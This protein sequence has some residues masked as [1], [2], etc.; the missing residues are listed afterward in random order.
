MKGRCKNV[1]Y[2]DFDGVL[3]HENV[4]WHP[5]RGAYLVAPPRYQLFQHAELLARE[6]A[7]F[8]DVEIVL[9]TSWVVQFGYDR[10]VRRLPASL[11]ERC[12]GATFHS[13]IMDAEAFRCFPRPLQIL[14]DV[15]SRRPASWIALDDCWDGMSGASHW[16]QTDPYEGL[17]GNGVIS[18]L[19][20]ALKSAHSNS[21]PRSE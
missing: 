1:L 12:I 11:G 7:S 6:L 2:L 17:A 9:S 5:K 15:E 21:F 20:R 10:T 4:L 19:R 13:R 8:P 18:K 16:I 14:V 3:H